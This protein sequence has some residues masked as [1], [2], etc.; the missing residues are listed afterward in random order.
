MKLANDLWVL[1]CLIDGSDPVWSER[2]T[3]VAT[4]E[5]IRSMLDLSHGLPFGWRLFK[6]KRARRFL[7]DSLKEE[8]RYRR[9][10]AAREKTGGN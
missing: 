3:I 6:G 9:D 1:T 2:A 10:R 5:R 7:R 8:A 4:P